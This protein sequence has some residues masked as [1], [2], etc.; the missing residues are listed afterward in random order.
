[1]SCDAPGAISVLQEGLAPGRPHSFP[2]A[3]GLVRFCL[4]LSVH[5]RGAG[6]LL[7]LHHS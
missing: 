7:T 1:M 2:Q 4:L 3:D 5:Q 6:W